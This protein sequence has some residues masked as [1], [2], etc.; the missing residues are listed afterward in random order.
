MEF[1]KAIVLGVIQ[2]LTEFL[3]V[4]SS[5]HLAIAGALFPAGAN[6]METTIIVLHLGTM[7]A[8]VI[9]FWKE[10]VTI[11]AAIPQI[12]SAIREKKA[13]D[14]LKMMW[15]II[16]ASIPTGLMGVFLAKYF[17]GLTQNLVLIGLMLLV[18][19]VILIITR[20]LSGGKLKEQKF[21]TLRAFILG[22]AQGFSI[23]PGI[24]R[25]GTTIA[26]SLYMGADRAFAGRI[27]FLISLPA[28]FAAVLL[29]FYKNMH[30]I[31]T[32][33]LA[34]L[35]VGLVVSFIVG[36]IALKLLLKLVEKGKIFW[37]SIYTFILG[38]ATIILRLAHLI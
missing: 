5:G 16:V 2:G 35:A 29:D 34:P 11:F 14:E 25:S 13:S 21:G 27:S 18:T 9:V 10:I 20:F 6:N 4:S 31:K 19:S 30:A 1:I 24:S 28:I 26:T 7:L 38:T 17:E 22:T 37:F 33:H 15:Y 36:Y 12:P 23:M 8:T 3:P 32:L